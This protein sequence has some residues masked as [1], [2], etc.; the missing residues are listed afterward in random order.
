MLRVSK[1]RTYTAPVVMRAL[2]I[3][4]FLFQ[5]SSSMKLD[6]IA[7]RTGVARSST[8]R[9]LGTLEQRGYV[10]RSLD[11]YYGYCGLRSQPNANSPHMNSRSNLQP[12]FPPSTPRT[13]EALWVEHAIET[14]V[15]LLQESRRSNTI[16]LRIKLDEWHPTNSAES[17]PRTRTGTGTLDALA[18]PNAIRS[19]QN[20]GLAVKSICPIV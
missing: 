5:S 18:R 1:R 14:L 15:E 2:D 10:S 19:G 6:E 11:G 8:Y 7:E 4:E 13:E 16:R 12:I 20:M 17:E 3:L 9:I